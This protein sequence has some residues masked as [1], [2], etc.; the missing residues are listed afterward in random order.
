MERMSRRRFLR[1]GAEAALGTAVGI[2]AHVLAPE[3]RR[4]TEEVDRWHYDETFRVRYKDELRFDFD[5][6]KQMTER[7]TRL[8]REMTPAFLPAEKKAVKSWMDEVVPFFSYNGIFKKVR[9][10]TDVEAK[11]TLDGLEHTNNLG[12]S[13]CKETIRFNNRFFNP[14]SS[15]KDSPIFPAA[16]V[17]ELDHIQQGE[18]VCSADP[19][20]A[21][22]P[23]EKHAQVATYEVLASMANGPNGGSPIAKTALITMIQRECLRSSYGLAAK[24]GRLE[25][26]TVFLQHLYPDA[27]ERAF[28]EQ[29]MRL[30]DQENVSPKILF[31][32]YSINPLRDMIESYRTDSKFPRTDIAVF[33]EY[34]QYG[35]SQTF[36][37]PA[38]PL[39]DFFYFMKYAEDFVAS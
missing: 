10:P 4:L 36:V 15:W 8:Q 34:G 39:D 13:N 3:L 20:Y 26:F 7:F 17:H 27:E 12:S 30:I 1:L 35:P 16:V 6:A 22:E 25:E 5:V 18:G 31:D 11:K 2:A 38:F 29:E 19:F 23:I 32:I 24:E 9:I 37:L 14:Y 21:T 28:F 33:G